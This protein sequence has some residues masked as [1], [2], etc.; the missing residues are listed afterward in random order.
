MKGLELYETAIQKEGDQQ[1]DFVVCKKVTNDNINTLFMEY[2]LTS[3]Y[4]QVKA[5]VDK[6]YINQ[7]EKALLGNQE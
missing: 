3:D 2:S 6:G 4:W 5:L 1:N 7:E